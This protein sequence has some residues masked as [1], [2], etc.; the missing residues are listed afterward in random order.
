MKTQ[1][2]F[3]LLLLV[4]VTTH[5][6]IWR[7]NNN[8][9][10]AADFTTLQAAHDGATAGDT[11]MLEMSNN[12]YGNCTFTKKLVVIGPGYYHGFYY[13]NT[14]ITKNAVVGTLQY[15]T[16]SSGSLIMGV[17]FA[18][19]GLLNVG[20]VS[21]ITIKN[22]AGFYLR[23]GHAPGGV[24]GNCSNIVIT[25]NLNC[26][27]NSYFQGGNTVT[28]IVVSNNLVNY[29]AI[30]S[31]ALGIVVSNNVFRAEGNNSLTCSGQVFSNNIL[32]GYVNIFDV[33]GSTVSNN[34]DA[35]T[36]GGT[37]FG[38]TNGNMGNVLATTLFKGGSISGN[39]FNFNYDGDFVLKSG[40]VAIG[41]GVGGTDCGMYGGS[42]PYKPGGFPLCAVAFCYWLV[43]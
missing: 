33:T 41:A 9:G 5:A 31:V 25:Q 24:G 12:S 11:L 43:A 32:V 42:S 15:N 37:R 35:S 34:I 7:V 6:K 8:P 2:I 38:T 19:G 20:N 36:A 14:P 1:S 21:N 17:V 4:A 28:N 13:P 18:S 39:E 16:G 23:L 40:S 29:M 26:A 22:N 30:T 27:I 3:L 10:I